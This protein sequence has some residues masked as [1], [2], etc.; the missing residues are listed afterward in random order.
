MAVPLSNLFFDL[1][2]VLIVDDSHDK[3]MTHDPR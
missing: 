2:V 3:L 1:D